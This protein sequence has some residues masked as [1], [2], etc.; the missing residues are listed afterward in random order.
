MSLVRPLEHADLQSV[1]NLLIRTFQGRNEPATPEMADYL[2]QLLLDLP[3]RDPEINSLVHVSDDRKITGFIGA[4]TQLMEVDGRVLRAAMGNSFAVDPEVRDPT[5]GARLLRAYFRGPQ[6]ITISDRCNAV[7]V[8]MW[9]GMGGSS[10]P[11]YSMEWR[12]TLRPISAATSRIRN[13]LKLRRATAPLTSALDGVAQRYA[14]RRGKVEWQLPTPPTRPPGLTRRDATDTDLL[15]AIP[16]LVSSARLHPVWSEA[17]LQTLLKHSA[18]KTELGE[19]IRQV[20]HDRSGRLVGAYVYYLEA[21]GFAQVLHVLS[22]KNMAEPVLDILLADAAER[23]AVAIGGRA[24]ANL[25]EP[26]MDRHAVLS[27]E[28]R[29]VFGSTDPAV[30]EAVE[31]G[32]AVVG[33]MVGELWTR[34]NG[35]GLK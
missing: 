3:D 14:K 35:D 12:R 22:A 32:D 19:T 21:Q 33:G 23:G 15:T 24:Q 10:L 8:G 16:E 6:D 1:A 9:R 31:H 11:T 28:Y 29:C 2:G 27:G 13:R 20:I 5:V 26:L 18:R 30:L 25:L 34:L 17:G 7:S 4:F